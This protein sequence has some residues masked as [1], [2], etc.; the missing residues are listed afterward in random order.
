MT[1]T[2]RQIH[3]RGHA[4]RL[5]TAVSVAPDLPIARLA[6]RLTIGQS[7]LKVVDG[8]GYGS[9]LRFGHGDALRA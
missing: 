7:A 2:G 8:A 5:S 3:R 1:M 6:R 4:P 9:A